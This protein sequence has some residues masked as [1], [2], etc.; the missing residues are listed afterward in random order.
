MSISVSLVCMYVHQVCA[1]TLRRS[2]EDYLQIIYIWSYEWLFATRGCC[3]P[4]LGPMQGQVLLTMEPSPQSSFMNSLGCILF[5][6]L[7]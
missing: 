6:P 5:P 4:N 3:R 7:S 1:W 2:Q